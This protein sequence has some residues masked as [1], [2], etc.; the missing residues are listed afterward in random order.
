M[1]LETILTKIKTDDEKG[2]RFLDLIEY[3]R[4]PQTPLIDSELPMFKTFFNEKSNFELSVLF[5]EGMKKYIQRKKDDYSLYGTFLF[6]NFF[7]S[8]N[9]RF[10]QM[11][12]STAKINSIFLEL[13]RQ[14]IEHDKNQPVEKLFEIFY[15][16][17]FQKIL[18]QML[19]S[20]NL[21]RRIS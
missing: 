8:I 16:E 14:K 7:S 20:G 21:I 10:S 15:V 1:K 18:S 2:T 13:I 4:K 12:F 6:S 17:L 19:S 5:L 3:F 11:I 9:N